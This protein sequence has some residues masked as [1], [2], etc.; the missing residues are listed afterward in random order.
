MMKKINL[1][2][3][4]IA[5]SYSYMYLHICLFLLFLTALFFSCGV[6]AADSVEVSFAKATAETSGLPFSQIDGASFYLPQLNCM[7]TDIRGKFRIGNGF[8][9]AAAIK[10]KI[11]S[12]EF[13]ARGIIAKG[14]NEH[15][16]RITSA[17]LKIEDMKKIF[18]ALAA[19]DIIAELKLDCLV[20][21]KA[22]SPVIDV[23]IES[24]SAVF[25]L[26]RFKSELKK[27]KTGKVKLNILSA[28]HK[29]EIKNF[30]FALLEG[31]AALSGIYDA[32][33]TSEAFLNLKADKINAAL[34]SSYFSA[35]DKKVSGTLGADFKIKNAASIKNYTASGKLSLRN[36]VLKDFDFLKKI[37]EK[38]RTP[39]DKLNYSYIGGDIQTSAGGGKV[40][41]KDFNLNSDI[42]KLKADGDIDENNMIKAKVSRK[43]R[44][45]F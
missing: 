17:A 3:K 31:F 42:I 44:A 7:I 12:S 18:P 38:L 8:I 24:D 33:N 40:F 22:A 5:G 30:S 23:K 39:V 11:M 26:S 36:G 4:L 34:L 32:Q 14:S 19:F 13:E 16:F 35:Y 9:E 10:F 29:Y 25:D 2:I 15:D 45:L 1:I 21:G 27:I 6:Y 41:F 20:K 37:G 43:L 28:N